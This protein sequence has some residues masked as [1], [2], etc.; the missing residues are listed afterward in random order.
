MAVHSGHVC[1]RAVPGYPELEAS[2]LGTVRRVL[3]TQTGYTARAGYVYQNKVM[4]NGYCMTRF[5]SDGTQY[6]VMTHRLIALAFLGLPKEATM[7]VNHKDHN[8]QNNCPEN[9]EWVTQ[10]CNTCYAHD[11]PGVTYHAR[12]GYY[13]ASIHACKR[14][15]YLGSFK[16]SAEASRVYQVAVREWEQEGLVT[17]HRRDGVYQATKAFFMWETNELQRVSSTNK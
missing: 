17:V 14:G 3:A 4:P 11:M 2:N 16:D 10:R 6:N 12:D 1:W 7:V 9:L 5:T 15:L 13:Q 8:R